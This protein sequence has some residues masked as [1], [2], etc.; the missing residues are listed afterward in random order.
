MLG[1]KDNA[2][3]WE[4]QML[5]KALERWL[6]LPVDMLIRSSTA[7][8]AVLHEHTMRDPCIAAKFY[9]YHGAE[10]CFNIRMRNTPLGTGNA[11]SPVPPPDL[12]RGYGEAYLESGK[13]DNEMIRGILKA[14]GHSL[15]PGNRILE[16]GCAEGRII[17]WFNDLSNDCE[18]WGVDIAADLIH[19]CQNNLN[20]RFKFLTT[21]SYP[22]LPF[23]DEYFDFIYSGSVF[24]HIA[25]LAETWLMELRRVLRAGGT[26]L[27]TISDDLTVSILMDP[28]RCPDYW[29]EFRES[30][31]KVVER[32]PT[33]DFSD[34]GM[35]A[36]NRKPG[37]GG[38]HDVHVFY[39]MDY[40][41]AHWGRFF[42]I[43]SR[44]PDAYGPQSAILLEK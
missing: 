44:T 41:K 8:P 3:E 21:T 17:R 39:H 12:L 29:R 10:T 25:D 15:Q 26:L 19:W 7:L 38:E 27:N 20:P 28:Q 43:L 42:K 32:E 18:V 13:R 33:V 2:R 11:E 9:A 6:R 1:S 36:I 24:T 16:F 5:K 35:I 31:L 37:S 22:H 40:I 4:T 23:E 14:S 34:Y 30:I